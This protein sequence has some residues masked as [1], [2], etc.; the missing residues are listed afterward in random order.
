MVKS[1]VVQSAMDQEL[2]P[3]MAM[4][5]LS[6]SGQR[7]EACAKA[8]SMS[9][10]P[11]EKAMN[12][13][14]TKSKKIECVV[15]GKTI[16]AIAEKHEFRENYT[17]HGLKNWPDVWVPISCSTQCDKWLSEPCPLFPPGGLGG[18]W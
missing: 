18:T 11:E 5:T 8:S 3:L 13:I 7:S 4:A 12:V 2:T 14:G 17:G 15:A 6:D 9:K 16:T 10:V 1:R